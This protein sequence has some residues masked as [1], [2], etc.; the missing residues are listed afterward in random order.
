M[1]LK[2]PYAFLI[3]HF[4][5]IHLIIAIPLIY[6]LVKS[7][8]LYAFLNDYVKSGYSFQTGS[9]VSSLYIT[10]LTL[11]SIIIIITALL[12]IYFLLK[13]KEK[14]VKWYISMITYY[15]GLFIVLFWLS[16]VI[17]SMSET[18]LSSKSVRLYRDIS[19]L[20]CLPQYIFIAF[21]LIRAIG[22]NL[23]SMNFQSDLKEMQITSAD[24]EEVEVGFE[25]DGYKTKRFFRR[26]KREFSYYLV[27]NKFIITC[28]VIIAIFTGIAIYYFS[29]ETYIK[30]YNLN[31]SFE[32][33]GFSVKVIDS[34]IT[35][36]DYNGNVLK[37][38]ESF[39][40]VKV[41]LTNNYYKNKVLDYNNFII[42][43]NDKIL[44]PTLDQSDYF[45]DYASPY[46]GE[47]IKSGS[48]RDYVLAYRLSKK[49]IK[50]S[51]TLKVLNEYHSEGNVVV[52]NYSKIDLE[53][54]N[55][56]EISDVANYRIND[57]IIFNNS[58][59]GETILTISNA[60]V[61]RN[62]TYNYE[63]CF[64][65]DNCTYKTDVVAV[66][67]S[68]GSTTSSLLVLDYDFD[69]DQETSYAKYTTDDLVFFENFVRVGN[70]DNNYS[71]INVTPKNMDGK[72]VLQ[73]NGNVI[74]TL[75][76]SMFIT[77]RNKRY[78][79]NLL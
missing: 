65:K 16:G 23:K 56:H 4:R 64:T 51:Y 63:Y 25:L 72:L 68:K 38:E 70:K 28:I 47:K 59:I 77:I 60:E 21:T 2:K 52:S 54:I 1:I 71:V 9:D 11:F 73:V 19:L 32:H 53:P 46:H 35:D 33:S 29:Q 42:T 12:A 27:E 76:L 8:G 30:T 61:T 78:I 20:I 74:N 13:Y 49:D 26:L 41:N 69:L 34:I 17:S 48:N 22:F 44:R 66:D 37:N 39:L 5:L 75:D 3:K 18:I 36:L 50:K 58:N 40:L 67:Y 55:I 43:I 31:E 10:G 62:Y 7:H 14:P 57:K 15:I 79:I 24:N 6:I 45:V